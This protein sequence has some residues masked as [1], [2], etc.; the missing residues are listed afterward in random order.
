LEKTS[1]CLRE[2][3][4]GF[5]GERKMLPQS[6]IQLAFNTFTY[7]EPN[8]GISLCLSPYVA[9]PIFGRKPNPPLPFVLSAEGLALMKKL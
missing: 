8:M 4:I 5:S 7:M 6:G 3:T 9:M 1:F 2:R